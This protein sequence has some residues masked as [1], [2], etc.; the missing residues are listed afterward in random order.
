[1]SGIDQ[2]PSTM[3]GKKNEKAIPAARVAHELVGVSGKA[4]WRSLDDLADTPDFRDFLE[5]EF[6][7]GASELH[8]ESRRTFLK[9]MGASVAL[10][11]AATIPGCRRPDHKI[12]AYSKEVPEE[13]IPGKGLYY[14]TSMPFPGGGAEGL[15]V[16]TFEGRPTKIEGNPLHPV[17]QGKSSVWAQASVLDLYDP[18]RLKDPVYAPKGEERVASWDDFAAWCKLHFPTLDASK[19]EGLAFIVDKQSSP[20]RDAV[21][22]RV[23]K[24]WPAAQWVAYD[25]TDSGAPAS[26]SAA[27]LGKP[28]RDRLALAGARVI[29][30]LDRDLL[31][32]EA[33]ALKHAREFAAGRRVLGLTDAMNRLYVVE[34]TL[35]VTGGVA[36]HR[37]RLAP[38]LIPAFAV[39]LGRAVIERLKPSGSDALAAALAAVAVPASAA[40]GV[41]KDWV[42]ALA[43]DLCDREN[44]GRSVLTAGPTQP[45][46][47]HALMAGLNTLLGNTKP[48][49]SAAPCVRYAEMG[50][51]E[52]MDGAAGLARVAQGLEAGKISTVVC[53]GVNPVYDAPAELGFAAK[54]AK[55][56]HRITLSVDDN[57]TS[58]ASTWRLNG[59]HYLESWGDAL[60]AEGDLSPIQPMIAPLYAGRSQIEAL[61]M[62]L[63]ESTVDGYEIVR[64]VWTA[65]L[66]EADFEKK[67]RRALHDGVAPRAGAEP[68]SPVA[69]LAGVAEAIKGLKL[70]DAPS[71]AALDVVF[72]VGHV[73]DGR[74]ANN[75]WLQELP[76][77]ASKLVWDNAALLSPAT[78]KKLGLEPQPQTVKEP[79][80]RM[81]TLTVAGR[82]VKLVCWVLPGLPDNTVAVHLGYGRERVGRVGQG[83]GFNAY[84]VR[85]GLG[86][87]ATGAKLEPVRE[88]EAWYPVSCTQIHHTME[89]RALVREVDLAAWRKHGEQIWR[90]KDLYGNDSDLGFAEQL[91]ELVE[92]PQVQG[93]Y[94]NPYHGSGDLGGP[95]MNPKF[96]KGPQWGMSIDLSSCL[97]CNACTIACQ[98]ENN[99]PIVGKTEVRKHREMHWIRVDRYFTG[100]E[101]NPGVVH[102]P[103]ACVHCENAPCETVCPVNATVHGQEGMNYMVYNRCIGTRY[104]ANNCPYKV[105]RFNFFD[106]GVAKFKGDYIG[107]ETLGA[108]GPKNPNLIPPRLRAKL[109]EIS[110]MQKNPH[111][112]VRSR[113]VME[114]CTYCVQRVNETKFAAR[115]E[116]RA[117]IADGEVLTAC[118]QACPTDAIVFG[119]ILD[120]ASHGGTGSAVRRMRGHA[121]SY[122]LLGY[123]NTRP[124][125]TYM[126][127]VN[128]PN[129]RLRAPVEDPFH[130]GPFKG[131]HKGGGHEAGGEAKGGH[132]SGRVYRRAGVSESGYLMSLPVLGAL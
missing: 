61:A 60:S 92:A 121:R 24:R 87:A 93:L 83:A 17:N 54:F 74:W 53:M 99:I 16:Q 47:V 30:S 77:P 106:Y 26:G 82:G 78:A 69:N 68:P 45:G 130:Y 112:S 124:R 37:L 25:P 103:V 51:D 109:D 88:G 79:H 118:Q 13:I 122:M 4:Y 111:V 52:A 63:G 49:G 129:P 64:D 44:L 110:K 123:L 19:G 58:G 70:A 33:G 20:T 98:A 27:A 107:K 91:G 127:R 101:S 105:R 40:S 59:A 102:Q 86:R 72:S 56:A 18:D 8:A 65:R 132:A 75:G 85:T 115:A 120:S 116:G 29:V 42:D 71:E 113:G 84:A 55:A 39:A 67:W 89:G 128:N 62:M 7:A 1:M 31:H 114:K 9:L 126:V 22:A 23:M 95:G 14:A 96:D 104:C 90:R 131:E 5:R 73:G 43:D 3:P 81:A 97:G 6:P 50:V 46:P 15:L 108:L 32:N 36:D 57:E 94:V 66:G 117:A 80:G 11:G 100:D 41:P 38:S 28:A 119:D 21:K 34:T 12:L 125:T 10:A 35:S 2:C 48:V 76:D